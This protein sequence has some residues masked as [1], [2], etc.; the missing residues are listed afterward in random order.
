MGTPCAGARGQLLQCCAARNQQSS[1]KTNGKKPAQPPKTRQ[2]TQAKQ[3]KEQQRQQVLDALAAVQRLSSADP[4]A[5]APAATVRQIENATDTS[6]LSADVHAPGS[7]AAVQAQPAAAPQPDVLPQ[8]RVA[9]AAR[10]Q[11]PETIVKKRKGATASAVPERIEGSLYDYPEYYEAAFAYRD[12]EAE[13]RRPPCTLHKAA[14]ACSLL[15]MGG[16]V[17]LDGMNCTCVSVHCPAYA[18]ATLGS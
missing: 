12:V 11:G 10:P 17:A 6:G 18:R 2:A 16:W 3:A 15:H 4:D 13:V 1:R 5:A 14:L 9:P 7:P 8:A